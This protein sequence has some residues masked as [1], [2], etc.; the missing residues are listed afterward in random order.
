MQYNTL[1]LTP[2]YNEEQKNSLVIMK[3]DEVLELHK[4]SRTTNI[5]TEAKSTQN[6]QKFTQMDAFP[7]RQTNAVCYDNPLSLPFRFPL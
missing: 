7:E 1:Y 5:M 3:M 6:R 2:F 4:D